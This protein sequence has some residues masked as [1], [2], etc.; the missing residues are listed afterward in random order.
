MA[1]LPPT[2]E[3]KA[4]IEQA[5][6]ERAP[7]MHASLTRAGELNRV[8][9][10]RVAQAQESYELAR[11][12]VSSNAL[13]ASRNLSH[14]EAASEI[15]QGLNSAAREALDQAIEFAPPPTGPTILLDPETSPAQALGKT[16]P[17]EI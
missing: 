12:Q 1:G 10:N 11:S 4:L 6:L 15:M 13:K 2:G 3:L 14:E 16:L 17:S 9:M 5:M 7:E 8:L